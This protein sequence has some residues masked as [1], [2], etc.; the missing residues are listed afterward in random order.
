MDTK[1]A[2]H[3]NAIPLIPSLNI[4]CRQF[5]VLPES[6]GSQLLEPFATVPLHLDVSKTKVISNKL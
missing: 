2:L 1:V 3:N 6:P 5:Q 4:F